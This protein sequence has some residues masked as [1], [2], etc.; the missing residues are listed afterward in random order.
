[1]FG[2]PV[3]PGK[4]PMD[5]LEQGVARIHDPWKKSN[6]KPAQ[7]PIPLLMGGVGEKRA[8]PLVAREAAEWNHSRLNRDEYKHKREV[9]D[10]CCQDI[11]RG[12][13]YLRYS[14]R[15]TYIGRSHKA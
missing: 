5:L 10:Q 11:G 2:M 8:L 15:T 4:E 12:P 13:S 14:G 3:L 9:L 1:M 7:N 6:P